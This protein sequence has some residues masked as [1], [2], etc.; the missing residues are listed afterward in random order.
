[1]YVKL[2][3]G[4]LDLNLRYYEIFFFCFFKVLKMLNYLWVIDCEIVVLGLI[5]WLF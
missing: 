4:D 3:I 2:N 5:R 1:M